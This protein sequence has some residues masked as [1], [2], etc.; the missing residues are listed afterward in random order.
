VAPWARALL[1]AAPVAVVFLL[2]G[3]RRV[4]AWKASLAGGFLALGLATT[5]WAL[6]WP[7][8]LAA[9]GYGVGT[10]LFPIVYIIF[11][12]LLL[13]HLTVVT[14]WAGRLRE[15]LAHIAQDRHLLLL[16][17]GFCFAAFLDSTAG[18][19][20]PVTVATVVLCGLG[21]PPLEAA[22]YTL[23]AASLPPIF[24]AMGIPVLVLADV[25][26]VPLAPLA[27]V[28][29][30]VAAVLFAGFPAYLTFAFGGRAVMRRL[31][32][33]SLAAGFA[34]S[35]ALWGTVTRVSLYPAALAG[36]LASLLA[37]GAVRVLR[38]RGQRPGGSDL[39]ASATPWWPYWVLMGA[40]SLWSVPA[41]ARALGKL[42]FVVPLAALPG[43]VWRVELLASPG[44]AILAATTVVAIAGRATRA[45]IGEALR[46]TTAQLRHPLVTM[47]AM[48]ALAQVLNASGMTHSM[49]QSLTGADGAFPFLSPFLSWLGAA[50][51]GSNTASNA[52]LGRLQAVTASQ[53]GLDPI[54]AL[55]FAGA[56]AALGKMAAPQVIAAAAAAGGIAGSE[57]RL[58]RVGLRHGLLWT[59]LVGMTA[60]LAHAWNGP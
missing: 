31:W 16:L 52:L 5:V 47:L 59:A 37:I 35:G 2:I 17:V 55:A 26:H 36:A 6:P 10:G 9:A 50:I 18:F 14:G 43:V 41:V 22:S 27:H 3:S 19:L 40:V 57:G 38:A 53:L 42:T 7:S 39:R 20:T 54:P 29:S 60:L 32:P 51:T 15:S 45:Q 24:G 30:I 48:L 58:L 25:A 56:G 49:G 8:A 33:E 44:T 4:A 34:Y 23:V 13:Y 12:S 28:Q 21:V 46:L 1:A 11:G